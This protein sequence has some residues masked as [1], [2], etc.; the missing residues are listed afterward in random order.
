MSEYGRVD[1]REYLKSPWW[2]L[3]RRRAILAA[4]HRCRICRV[5]AR[6]EVHHLTYERLGNERPEDVIA[7]CGP[8]HADQ[9]D[10]P[11]RPRGNPYQNLPEHMAPIL[12][13]VLTKIWPADGRSAA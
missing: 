10:A 4:G 8:C 9:H 5:S 6:L 7:L 2:K 3:V 12:G 13:R 1:Y 11:Y